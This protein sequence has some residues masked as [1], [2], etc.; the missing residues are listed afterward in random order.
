MSVD[1]NQLEN[2]QLLSSENEASSPFKESIPS[3]S[4]LYLIAL[5]VSLLGVQLTWSVE[6]GYGTPYLFSLGLRKEW[7]SIIWIAGP[8]TGIL[9]QPIAGILSDR[10][11]SRIGRRR[12]FM[13][14]ASL[15]GTFS[16]FLMGWAPDIC[17]FIF[18]NEVLM[19]RVTIVL[20]T[21]S[22]YLLDV[23]VN[24]VMASTRSLIVDSVRSDQQHEANSWAGRMIGVGNVLGYLLGYL[25]LYRIFSFLN[26]TQLQVFCVLASI[27]LVL[28]VTITTIFVSE[29]RFPP[30]EHEKS[31]A[32]EIFEFF[33]TMRQ[34]ITALPFTLKR[35]CF[36]QFFAYFGWFP[37]LFYITTYVG[38]LYLRHAPKGHEEDW[39]M[40]TRQGS[41]ALLLFAIISLAA[42]T[43]LPLLL[44][45]TEDDEEDESSDASN[46][47]YNIQERN[48]LGNIR[49]GTNTPRLG[50]LSETTSFRSENEPSRRRLL[51]SSRSIMT[52]ISSKVQIKGLTLPILWL[53]SHVLFGVCMLS[54]IFLQT[55]WQAQAM[56]AIC[57]LSWACTLWIP[58]SLFSSEIGKLGLRESS[59]KMIGVHNVFISAPQ[60]LST[61]IA[62]IVFIQS[63]GSHRDIADNSIAWVL[64]IGGISA[65]LAAYQCRHLLPINF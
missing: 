12:P 30:V 41:F 6:L 56:V 31:V 8:L 55:S 50:N 60:V 62:T 38:I 2:G 9:I 7:T 45:D 61:I 25:P 27:S 52:T 1:E 21:I 26:F 64:R 32:G 34:S 53:S 23:A 13:L 33:T 37:F 17:L 42:N 63:E 43:A 57:G 24:V 54:T 65:F 15:L 35:I 14:C 18:S 48:D 5:T 44:E 20:A 58:Y 40:A 11:N 47:E 3:R 29:R 22:I 46:N 36:V 28:T 4:S 51:P 19:K 10:V 49:T 39:D 59:G 16:L